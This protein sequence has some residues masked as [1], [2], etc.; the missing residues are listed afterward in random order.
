MIIGKKAPFFSCQAVVDGQ[1]K[2][3][4]LDDFKGQY[5]ILFFY[6]LDFTFVCPT[7]LHAFQE[8]LHAFTERGAVVLGISVDSVYSHLAWLAQ[9]REQG[10]IQGVNYPLLSDIT[11]SIARAYEVLN[12]ETGVAYRGLFIIDD[13]DIVQAEQLNNLSLGRNTEEVLRLLDALKFTKTQGEVCP[14]NWTIG[15][16]GLKPTKAGLA[17]YFS[18]K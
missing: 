1:I 3:I 7:E 9:P 8:D 14:A 17:E 18:K 15:K 5:K 12:E 13:E 10:G 16:K 11:K 6:P 4:S 2:E